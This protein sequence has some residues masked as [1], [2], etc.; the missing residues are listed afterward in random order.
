MSS[1]IKPKLEEKK[2]KNGIGPG[3]YKGTQNA[4]KKTM[5]N[6]PNFS[7]GR[8]KTPSVYHFIALKAKSTPGV[9]AYKE[10][11]EAF[12]TFALSKSRSPVIFPYKIKRFIERVMH[13]SKATPGPG[14][15]EIIPPLKKF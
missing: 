14:S 10:S 15:Y 3:D 4:I 6:S 12:K 1:W 13:E 7:F 9:G 11:D 5:K 2:T 8:S